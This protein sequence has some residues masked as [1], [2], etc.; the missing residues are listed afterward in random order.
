MNTTGAVTGGL[1][2]VV[3]GLA[4][5]GYQIGRWRGG[6][7]PTPKVHFFAGVAMAALLFLG[8][9]ILGA[10]GGTTAALGGGLGQYALESGTGT[11]VPA[12]GAHP[13][14]TGSEHVS[15]YGVAAG[16][17]LLTIYAGLIKSGRVDLRSALIR[18]VLC[19]IWL[20]TSAGLIGLSLGLI[21]TS[22]NS[23]GTLL[24]TGL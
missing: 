14:L 11:A 13:P 17:F 7:D 9:G 23:V 6:G 4:V 5:L 15:V 12:G 1:T 19:G 10:M 20:A 21:R 3:A 18:G 16:I 8:G 2:S 24:V 22:G